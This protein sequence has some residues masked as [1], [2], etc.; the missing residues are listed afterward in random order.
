MNESLLQS[1]IQ[2]FAIVVETEEGGISES[3]HRVIADFLRKEFSREQVDEYL[4]E[5][6]F[7]HAVITKKNKQTPLDISLKDRIEFI[8]KKINS[9]YEQHQKVWLALQL[10]EFIVDMGYVSNRQLNF[11]QSIAE[12]FNISLEEYTNGK[13]F[14]LATNP[15]E[16]PQNS[17]I[18][19]IG[20]DEA[21][22]EIQ[23][24][25]F[26]SNFQGELFF[27]HIPSTNTLLAKYF[28]ESNLFLNSK[29]LKPGRAYIFGVGGVIRSP[30]VEPIYYSKIAG[31]FFQSWSKT[32]I[33]ITAE[34]IEYK[35]K[36]SKDGV[37]PFT[38][39]AH[40][41]Q[42][43]S[44]MG[45]S[46]V[47]K[48]TLI[49][50]LNG[51]FKPASGQVVINGFNINFDKDV[52]QG[53]VGYVPQDDLLVE[54]LTVFQNLYFGAKL[55]FSNK[56]EKEILSLVDET[57]K[58]FDL[59]EAR[60]LK[61]GNPINKF[62]SGG[63]RKRLNIAMELIREPAILFVDEPTSGLSSFDSERIILLLKR[64]TFKGKIVIANVHQPS[65]D[66]YK[67]FDKVLVMDHGGRII[68]QGNPMDA[69]V[70]FKQEGQ[71]LKADE[72]ECL[73]CGN[74]NTELILRVIEARVVNEYGKLTRKRKRSADEW[75]ELYLERIQSKINPTSHLVKQKLPD[76]SF[77][78]PS[79][80]QQSLLYFK[81]DLLSK[82]A[83]RQFMLIALI[84]AP[85]L[86]LVLGFFTKYISGTLNNPDAY[87]YSNNDNIPSFLFMSVVAAIFMGLT[88]S[89]EEIIRDQKVRKRE[90]FLNLSYFSYINS[91]IISLL[92][93]SAFQTL[94]F[95]AIGNYILEIQGHF[96]STWL[97]LFSTA[98]CA[99]L[100]GLNISAALNSVV[101]IYITIPLIIIP[102]LLLSGVVVSY[103]RLHKSILHP[104]YVPVIGDINPIR[105]SYEAF[106]V[107]Q[108]KRN[109]F[110]R[111]FFELDQRLSNNIYYA[112]F[113][114][115]RL[116]I[117]LEEVSRS[118][119]SGK[120]TKV[121]HNELRL[122][123]REL[124][125]IKDELFFTGVQYPD[126]SILNPYNIT[127]A[128]INVVKDFF[129]N[130]RNSLTNDYKFVNSQKDLVYEDLVSKLG[131][132]DEVFKL[133][134]TYHNSA[135]EDLVLNKS[136]L[137]KISTDGNRLIRKYHQVYSIPRATNGRAHMFAPVKRIGNLKIDTL[138]FN[139]MVLWLMSFVFYITLL[140][141]LLRAINMYLE[142]FKFRRLAKRI[143]RYIPR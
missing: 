17:N 67:L 40:S 39:D 52:L 98:V 127:I 138:W 19:K 51:N 123:T 133:K 50:L 30:R 134:R 10:V 55:C 73:C 103:G 124:Q 44:I 7:S 91:K 128:E 135:I 60:N 23:N 45:G 34:N 12:E 64:Q 120:V 116:Q 8:S 81:R 28:G 114:I 38:F 58:D 35:H 27:I 122:V 63:Q 86:A 80:W 14:I 15:Q 26:V 94:L 136:E 99:N 41:G 89:A 118:I 59:D 70:Y 56:T 18:I 75:Y 101:T 82:F 126:T 48:S 32:N 109:K 61:V 121:T 119:Y 84:E 66:I 37:Y 115:P 11:I 20:G 140:T 46:G 129:T 57:L 9:E 29:A 143:A 6:G 53:V 132:T 21:T 76:N 65:S 92:L 2:L 87:I 102:M 83:N 141:N 33:R 74:V 97:I 68:F 106:C 108:F 42:L 107:H 43:I 142:R 139:V 95:T 49:N 113:L 93:F 110:N 62:I 111:N 88:L 1:L 47:G 54:D 5:V 96:L 125:I 112:S 130:I 85:L 104:E 100:I 79:R 22:T 117:T 78:T 36:G 3:A 4:K 72:S 105:W 77:S 24:Q 31:V 137:E 69:V 16:M 131:G 25:L 71:F 13:D 90:K